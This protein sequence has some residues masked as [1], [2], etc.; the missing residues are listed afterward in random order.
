M[1]G[2]ANTD[3]EQDAQAVSRCRAGRPDAFAA[4]VE[5][6]QAAVYATVLRLV[7]ERD[8]ALEIANTAFYKAYRALA[9]VDTSRP[10]RPW[11]L[12]IAS[13]EALSHLR[14]RSR[15]ARRTVAG[16]ASEVAPDFERAHLARPSVIANAATIS[17]AKPVRRTCA[18]A[19]LTVCTLPPPKWGR[20]PACGCHRL[21]AP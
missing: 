6:H 21:H 18:T 20:R 7:G 13:N 10:L 5:R 4:I 17:S 12:R 3:Q 19:G 15:T 9:S 1:S 11:L 2:P 8:T 16:E 14:E